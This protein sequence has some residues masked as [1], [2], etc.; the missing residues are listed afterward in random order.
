M[1]AKAKAAK[2]KGKID[3]RIVRSLILIVAIIA[4]SCSLLVG[5]SQYR[6][7][8]NKK[9]PE[10]AA[11]EFLSSL[12]LGN[13]ADAYTQLCSTVKRGYPEAQFADGVE[14]GPPIK[15]HTIK[16]T[17]VTTV[18]GASSAVVTLSITQSSGTAHSLQLVMADQD[19]TWLA[20]AKPPY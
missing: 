1:M 18:N 13:V 12:E 14:Q 7:S 20:C 15:G 4:I 17:D 10:R 6:D 8:Q 9:A 11:N 5:Y 2:A 19:G 3:P 16:S